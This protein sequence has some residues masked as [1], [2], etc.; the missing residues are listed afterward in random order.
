MPNNDDM[1]KLRTLAESKGFAAEYA[2]ST[3]RYVRLWSPFIQGNIKGPDGSAALTF[4]QAFEILKRESDV[5][6]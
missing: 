2:L 5:V 3:K 6:A 1:V 4:R